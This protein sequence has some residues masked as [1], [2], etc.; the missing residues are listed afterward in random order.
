MK[1]ALVLGGTMFFGKKLVTHLLNAGFNV[2]I[3]TRGLTEDDFGDKV[4]RIKIDRGNRE[5]LLPLAEQKWDLVY[6]QSCYSP[7][8]ALDITEVLASKVGRL[9]FTSTS[10]VYE[11]GRDL[12]EE[13][14]DPYHFEIGELYD[15]SH[16]KGVVGYQQAKRQAEAVY[17]QKAD[18]P[19]VAVRPTYVVGEDDFSKRLKFYVEKVKHEEEMYIPKLDNV[20]D[21]ITSD[22][23][24]HFLYWLGSSDFVGPINAGSKDD[25]T[26]QAFIEMIE[27]IV[28]KKAILTDNQEAATPYV[29]FTHFSE[30]MEKAEQLGYKFPTVSEILP[31]LIKYYA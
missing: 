28:G 27:N 1:S 23:A 30:N 5:S 16:Y 10:A 25:I 9:I 24:G 19:V 4:Q 26:F 22:D 2:T 15:R 21:F 17:F 14:F 11:G 18:F 31:K 20:L 8:E 6:D 29:L 7:Q 12:R 13:Q 3:A